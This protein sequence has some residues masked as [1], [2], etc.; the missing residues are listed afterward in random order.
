MNTTYIPTID[1][2]KTGRSKFALA[3]SICKPLTA[4]LRVGYK[5]FTSKQTSFNAAMSYILNNAII[6]EY[7]NYTVSISKVL[8]SRG[9]LAGVLNGFTTYQNCEISINWTDNSGNG[10]AKPSDNSMIAI[11]NISKDEAIYEIDGRQRLVGSHT[12]KIPADWKGDCVEVFLSF[13]SEDRKE[14]S[15]SSH[16]SF[17]II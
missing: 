5:N 16:I 8:V 10:N 7:P 13:I 12:I 3:L 14:V 15:D 4:F 1:L 9:T 11:L 6:G 2:Q 17:I